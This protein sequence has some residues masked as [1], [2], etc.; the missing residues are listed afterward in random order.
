[1]LLNKAN[2]I[3]IGAFTK[4]IQRIFTSNNKCFEKLKNQQTDQWLL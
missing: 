4:L 1:M 3:A 2:Y